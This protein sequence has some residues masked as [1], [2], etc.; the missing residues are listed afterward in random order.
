[1]YMADQ[2]LDEST[3]KLISQAPLNLLFNPS[4]LNKKDVWDVDITILLELLLRLI[5]K[6]EKKDLRLCGLALLTSSIVHRLKVETIFNL[7][8]IAMQ[9]KEIEPNYEL[10]AP[11]PELNAMQIP[12]RH[13]SMYPVSV[14]DLLR[15]LEN[16]L[17]EIDNSRIKNKD[18]RLEPVES[19]VNLND[20]L[21]KFEEQLQV[22]ENSIMNLLDARG[23]ECSFNQI[24]S[25]M[26]TIEA[27]RYFIALLYLATKR[28][29]LLKQSDVTITDA[30]IKISAVPSNV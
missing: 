10:H 8:K 25:K 19:F 24:I 1:M 6:S 14:D 2:S 13:E 4:V 26:E 7:E 21:L 22:Y 3:R 23:A 17:H 27:I 16:L 5:N 12:Y 15:V 20:Y 9:K 11:I 28:R 18:M 30:D 29:V